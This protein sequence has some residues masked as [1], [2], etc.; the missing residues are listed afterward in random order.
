MRK[1]ELRGLAV[2]ALIIL[3][4]LV[5]GLTVIKPVMENF[6][7]VKMS[8]FG[9]IIVVI[10]LAYVFNI[11]GLE[12]L[13]VLGAVL[14]GYSVTLVNVLGICLDKKKDKWTL[15]FK[16]F[17]GL[18]GE[19]RIAPKKEK[20]NIN[21]F[22]WCPIF[23]YAAELAACIVIYSTI[24]ASLE[25]T[26]PWLASAAIIFLLISSLL[27]VYNLIPFRLDSITDGYRIRLFSNPVNLKAYNEVLK[28]NEQKRRGENVE[29]ITIFPEITEYTAQLNILAAYDYLAKENY[30]EALK[31]VDEILKNEKVIQG[32]EYIRLIAQKLYLEI[33]LHPIEDVKAY[34]EKNCD[35]EIRRFIANDTS[36]ESIRA[37]ILIAGMIEDSESEVQYAKSKIEKSKRKSLETQIKVEEAL[38]QKAIEY[39][40]SKHPKWSKEN[41]AN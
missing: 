40:Y 32:K 22:V 34:Y 37:Y 3:I 30:E 18:T 23:G 28:I 39:V 16:D 27:A 25:P 31:I 21:Y 11:L 26:A 17:D 2:Y 15:C 10:I 12:L 8:S 41:T 13:H 1:E 4:A 35:D 14:G 29:K 38:T 7:P 33:M 6:S 9:F 24:K 36:M 19:T 20:T 5:V